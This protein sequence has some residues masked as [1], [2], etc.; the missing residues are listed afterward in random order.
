MPA[1]YQPLHLYEHFKIQ[2]TARYVCC[3]TPV[4]NHLHAV[5][6]NWRT[7]LPRSSVSRR[8]EV[9]MQKRN[10]NQC[11]VNKNYGSLLSLNQNWFLSSVL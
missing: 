11:D 6:H 2:D 9:C 5:S 3:I 1:D 8:T 10:R 4:M 7:L